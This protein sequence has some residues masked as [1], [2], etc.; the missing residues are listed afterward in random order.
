VIDSRRAGNIAIVLSR[1]SSVPWAA[2]QH[3]VAA[4]DPAATAAAFPGAGITEESLRALIA[5]APTV[6]GAGVGVRGRSTDAS[7]SPPHACLAPHL[8]CVQ[9]EERAALTRHCAT[10]PGAE[11]TLSLPDRHL[12]RV[13][14]AP[15]AFMPRARLL[16]AR[17]DWAPGV[18]SA[19]SKAA[20][21]ESACA[22]LQASPTFG[23]LL[24][25]IL[26][27]GNALNAH[28][29]AHGIGG[30]GSSKGQQKPAPAPAATAV[31]GTAA[32]SEDTSAPAALPPPPQLAGF[33]LDSLVRL[34]TTR[35][36]DRKTSA[37][38][39]VVQVRAAGG[40]RG[41]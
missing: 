23:R 5:L 21:L 27:L 15:G 14:T 28:A 22:Q 31:G 12:H 41:A 2:L 25:L 38:A 19:A 6:R 1:F 39:F 33:S 9:A 7:H 8:D 4:L 34:S 10:A 3:A 37:L 24:R 16:L 11:A 35:A 17:L 32:T 26:A 36:Y 20:A 29:V 30:G 18:A 13:G 40:R